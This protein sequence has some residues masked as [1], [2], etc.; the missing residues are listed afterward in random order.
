MRNRDILRLAKLMPVGT[1]VT[2]R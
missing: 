1:P 2:V